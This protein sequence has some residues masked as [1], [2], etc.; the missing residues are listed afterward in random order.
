MSPFA[1]VCVSI[2]LPYTLQVGPAIEQ[3]TVAFR[4]PAHC[5]EGYLPN[6]AVLPQSEAL[7][8]VPPPPP[9]TV[10]KAKKPG[11]R[12]PCKPG[13]TR[14]SRGFCGRWG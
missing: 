7:A 8:A 11:R 13:R 10:A 3:G 1:A 12:P 9:K 14:N 5:S 2:V 4:T 6:A